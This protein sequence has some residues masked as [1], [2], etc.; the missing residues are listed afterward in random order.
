MDYPWESKNIESLWD[1][2][3]I[4][5]FI[6]I[7]LIKLIGLIK[8]EIHYLKDQFMK[9]VYGSKNVLK[10]KIKLKSTMREYVYTRIHAHKELSFSYTKG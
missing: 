9:L 1:F 7:I 6:L 3:E 5:R 2:L 4:L 10:I 8:P